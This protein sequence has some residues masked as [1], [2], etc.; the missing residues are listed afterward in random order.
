MTTTESLEQ[1]KKISA[2][3]DDNFISRLDDVAPISE[4][5]EAGQFRA[6][7]EEEAPI[8]S[9]F[10]QE[11][12]GTNTE[13]ATLSPLKNPRHSLE[14]NNSFLSRRGVTA[15]SSRMGSQDRLQNNV[16]SY[17][18]KNSDLAVDSMTRRRKGQR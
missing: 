16:L 3:E 10:P 11:L 1:L 4:K 5:H 2:E 12:L 9:S 15:S 17:A 7:L 18:D 8:E 14:E 13:K 6:G